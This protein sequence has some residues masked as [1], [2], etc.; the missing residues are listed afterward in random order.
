MVAFDIAFHALEAFRIL[1]ALGRLTIQSV[2]DVIVGQTALI[3]LDRLNP[4]ESQ[5]VVQIGLADVE[6]VVSAG[7]STSAST[8]RFCVLSPLG[9]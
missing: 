3:V 4:V 7:S 1:T 6:V 9:R 5:R 8:P 2:D